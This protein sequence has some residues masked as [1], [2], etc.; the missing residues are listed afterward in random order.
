MSEKKICGGD[1]PLKCIKSVKK[2]STLNY[3]RYLMNILNTLLWLGVT[4]R[5]DL[6]LPMSCLITNQTKQ[7]YVTAHQY[8]HCAVYSANA[9]TIQNIIY[10]IVGKRKCTDTQMPKLYTRFVPMD[11]RIRKFQSSKHI[12]I[13]LVGKYVRECTNMKTQHLKHIINIV[14]TL[15]KHLKLY[16]ILV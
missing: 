2:L 10:C 3:L 5:S 15:Y 11:K 6:R 4:G 12:E 14:N 9:H 13:V 8:A 7:Q 1:L 16:T